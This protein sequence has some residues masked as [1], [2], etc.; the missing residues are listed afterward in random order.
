MGPY[1]P[2]TV[3]TEMSAVGG[4]L[5][6]GIAVNMLQLGRDKLKVG[7]MLPAIF[8]PILYV[9]LSGWLSRLVG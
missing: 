3:I 8:L 1:L 7:N 5:I 4:A 2:E 9:P 6:V